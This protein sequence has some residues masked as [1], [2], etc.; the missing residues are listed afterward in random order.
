LPAR[1]IREF[2]HFKV[3]QSIITQFFSKV[4]HYRESHKKIILKFSAKLSP[5]RTHSLAWKVSRMILC[6]SLSLFTFV[7]LYIYIY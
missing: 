2:F 7:S 3:E 5:L 1:K 4:Y 6:F